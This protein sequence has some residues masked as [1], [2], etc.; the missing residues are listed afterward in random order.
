MRLTEEWSTQYNR[1]AVVT[2]SRRGFNPQNFLEYA[3]GIGA[4]QANKDG[5]DC[6]VAK[7]PGDRWPKLYTRKEVLLLG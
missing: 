5:D 1:L 6:V 2:D 7:M 3:E 4:E